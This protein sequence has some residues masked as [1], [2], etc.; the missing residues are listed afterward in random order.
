MNGDVISLPAAPVRRRGLPALNALIGGGLLLGLVALALLGLV[1]TPY[2]P[3]KLD[4]SLRL[5]APGARHWLGTDEF[6]RDVLS[7]LIIGASTSLWISLLSVAVALGCGTLIGML[8]GYLRGWT[9][10]ILMMFNDALLA[11]P[12]ILL[13]LG[14]MAVLGAS[15]YSIVLA[16]G[17]AYTPSVVRV[18]RGSV[19]SL[20]EREF[21]EA[22]RVIGNSELYTMFRHIVPNCLAPVCVLAT[23]MF[24]WALLSESALSFLGLGVPPPAATWGSMLAASRPYIASAAWLGVFPGV[25]ISMALLGINL[26]GDALRDRLDPR[27]RK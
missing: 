22:S 12:G 5:Q 26:F 6:G 4:L 2:D 7:R 10:R 11:F 17:M 1:W 9:D 3:L 23:S 24:G 16:L 13:A 27:M 25:L 8:A 14:I 21:I 15:Q 19:L 20:R 18:V